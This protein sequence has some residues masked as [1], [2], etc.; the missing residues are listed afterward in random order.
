MNI[1]N[2]KEENFINGNNDLIESEK[3][4]L[5]KE[6]RVFKL[7]IAKEKN[8]I[9]IK[10]RNYKFQLNDNDLSILTKLEFNSISQAYEFIIDS[11]EENRIII[12]DIIDKKLIS[13]LLSYSNGNN[14]EDNCFEIN[15]LYNK[16]NDNLNKITK[17][18]FKNT[19][20]ELKAE[21]NILK[22]EIKELKNHIKIRNNIQNKDISIKNEIDI[23]NITYS[24]DLTKDSYVFNNLDNS[25]CS[26]KS[27]NNI[28]YLIYVNMYNSLISYDLID[29]K[30]II[31]IKNAHSKYITNLRHYLDKLNKRDLIMSVSNN[32]NNIILW[33]VNN[34]E[35]LLNF[36]NIIKNRDLYSACF[37]NDNNINY[38]ITSNYNWAGNS[39]PIKLFDFNGIKIKEIKDS[40]D[41][42]VFVDTYYDKTLCKNF[43]ITGN[44]G[45]IKSYDYDENKIYHKYCD[46]DNKHHDSVVI[47]NNEDIIKL[48]DS[49]KDGVI[50]IWNFHSGLLLKKVKISKDYNL[51]GLCLWNKDYLFVGCE[52]KTIKLIELKSG[53]N[54]KNLIGHN[55]RV[56]TIK[57]IILPKYGECLISQGYNND[58][59][60]LWINKS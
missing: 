18:E 54:I 30:K 33:N 48:I 28:Y 39:E 13:L 8:E 11:F 45:F 53:K 31:E 35:C 22:N 25:F 20:A 57:K 41:R 47:N 9:I 49:C 42:T 2:I 5:S 23:K 27:I 40:C 52:D 10:Y 17:N 36:K 15:L 58:Q 44:K 59:I 51:Y 19:Y 14:I 34:W 56:I 7:T 37:F 1:Y 32:D 4:Y 3:F 50:R 6:N 60:K 55:N 16:Q 29:N 43:I 24:K 12:K 38:I 26:F 46:N 21:I